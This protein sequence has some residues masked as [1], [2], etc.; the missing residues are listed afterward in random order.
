MYV[1]CKKEYTLTSMCKQ[2]LAHSKVELLY[3][4]FSLQDRKKLTHKKVG[5]YFYL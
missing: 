3:V 2:K 5:V 4:P 1:I